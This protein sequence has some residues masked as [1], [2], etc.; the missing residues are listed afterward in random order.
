M[1]KIANCETNLW[2]KF[3]H[4]IYFAYLFRSH[5]S[6]LLKNVSSCHGTNEKE[7]KGDHNLE[8][9]LLNPV[10]LPLVPFIT[11]IW[12]RTR[13]INWFWFCPSQL[14][15]RL[16]PR[17]TSFVVYSECFHDFIFLLIPGASQWQS[18]ST[19][20]TSWRRIPASLLQRSHRKSVSS[21]DSK[22]PLTSSA[23]ACLSNQGR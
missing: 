21:R 23:H 10:D 8:L 16:P 12:Q 7:I 1:K 11:T 3:D 15:Y 9:F 4:I 19:L 18:S 22:D 13:A 14:L 6:L 5:W 20:S 17:M 2:L